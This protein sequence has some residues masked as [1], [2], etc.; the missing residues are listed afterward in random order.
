MKVKQFLR[1]LSKTVLNSSETLTNSEIMPALVMRHSS[2]GI[3]SSASSNKLKIL[4]VTI[5]TETESY[6]CNQIKLCFRSL[7]LL[8]QQIILDGVPLYLEDMYKLPD[9]TPG[10]YQ[11]FIGSKFLV[12]RTHGNF[13]AVGADYK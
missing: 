5:V 11:A 6:T 7:Q 13:N 10:V 4:F 12:K 2:I 8:T 9:T 3:L 1:N